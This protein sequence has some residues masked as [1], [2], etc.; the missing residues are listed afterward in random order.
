MGATTEVWEP[1]AAELAGRP[2]IPDGLDFDGRPQL[3]ARFLGEGTGRSLMFNGHIDVVS[4]E[5]RDRWTSDPN[6]AEV[7]DGKLYGRGACDM[8]GGVAAM[9][10]AAET[11]ARLEVRLGGD[12]LVCTNTDEE[13]SGAGGMALVAHG[14]RADAGVVPEPTGFDAWIACRGSSLVTIEVAGQAGHAEM[15]QPH[16]RAGGG[17]NAVEKMTLVLAAIEALRNDWHRRDELARHA[18]L[19]PGDIVPTVI[20]GGEWVVTYPSSCRVTCVAAYPP[21]QADADGWATRIAAE[22]EETI[23]RATAD[24]DWLSEHP[25][26]ITWHSGVTPMEMSPDEPIVETVLAAA[27]DVRRIGKAAGLDSWYDGATFTQ[28]ADTP[29]LAFGPSGLDGERT[30]AHTVDE[31]V[32]VDDLVACSQALALVALRFCGTA[33]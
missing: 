19:S 7:R 23:A 5:P 10:F 1:S 13:S 2:L 14:V 22:L 4:S 9:T 26:S 18:Y 20:A 16:W 6:A 31:F 3:V 17:V 21:A 28:F 30:L 15:P 33:A 25:P 32:R 12:L 29:T 11:L 8:K 27:R 24:D